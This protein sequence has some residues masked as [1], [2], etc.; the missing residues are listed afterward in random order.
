LLLEPKCVTPVDQLEKWQSLEEVDFS[1]NEL[2]ELDEAV[3][4]LGPVQKMNLSH[5]HIS[6]IGIHL[7]HLTNLT[8]LDL[9]QNAIEMV[10]KWHTKLGNLKRLNLSGNSVRSLRGLRKLYS[11]EVLNVR[12]N[13][14]IH[15]EQVWPIGD[16][17]CLVQLQMDG[18]PVQQVVEYRT[19]VL[20]AF[21]S[22][23]H[24]IILDD[25]KADRRELDTVG[26]RQAMHKAKREKEEQLRIRNKQINDRLQL[27]SGDDHGMTIRMVHDSGDDDQLHLSESAPPMLG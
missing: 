10:D 18:N 20:E 19:R 13:S 16:L 21:G 17:P 4:L 25:S 1:F 23:A 5:N 8:E 22:R 11:L 15:I 27:L 14:I 2:G 7:Q 3:V 6:D 24:E 12:D 26:V 9:S